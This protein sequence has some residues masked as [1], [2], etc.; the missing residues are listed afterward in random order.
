MHIAL[1]SMQKMQQKFPGKPDPGNVPSFL[2]I[3]VPV[4][5]AHHGNVMDQNAC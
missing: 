4:P 3:P 1:P 5:W 2:I